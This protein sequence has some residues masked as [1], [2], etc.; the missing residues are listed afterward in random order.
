MSRTMFQLPSVIRER[1]WRTAS[2]LGCVAAA[3]VA[4]LGST[5]ALA[6]LGMKPP[7]EME[8]VDVEEKLGNQLPLHLEFTN[9]DGKLVPLSTYFKNDKRPALLLMVYYD[10]P[11]VCDVLMQRLSETINEIDLNVGEDYEVLLFSINPSETAEKARVVREGFLAGYNREVTQ[12]V[13]D[14]WQFHVSDGAAAQELANAVGFKYKKLA[15]GE[16]SHPVVLFVIT[17]EGM[18][19]RYVYGFTYPVRD[20]KL[21][22]IEASEGRLAKTIGDRLMAFCFM[23]DPTTGSYSM[24]AFRVMQ[25]GGMITLILLS[26]MIGILVI[27]ERYRRRLRA[28]DADTEDTD[29]AGTGTTPT[30]LPQ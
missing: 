17:P 16:F 10:C 18:I 12:E 5:P 21:S 20:V 29:N 11:V 6:Q 30:A 22:L 14:A 9:A 23:F 13:R 7:A 27:S 2:V 3:A 28:R 8:G 4:C 1:I 24:V 19:S 26:G 25:I 15:N